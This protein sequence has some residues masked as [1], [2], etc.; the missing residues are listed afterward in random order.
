MTPEEL[1]ERQKR[2]S[3][4]PWEKYAEGRSDYKM[5]EVQIIVSS[6]SPLKIGIVGLLVPLVVWLL[7]EGVVLVALWVIAGFS[8]GKGK[9]S[10]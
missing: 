7:M 8:A 2:E 10:N 6:A 4:K 9:S 5:D 1:A 3:G